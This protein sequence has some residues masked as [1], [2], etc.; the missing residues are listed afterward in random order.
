VYSKQYEFT[1]LKSTRKHRMTK[2]IIKVI[3]IYIIISQNIFAQQQTS[4]KNIGEKMK[5]TFQ[6]LKEITKVPYLAGQEYY[7]KHNKSVYYHKGNLELTELNMDQSYNDCAILYV[8]GDLIVKNNIDNSYSDIGTVLIVNGNVKAK[9]IFAGGSEIK[10][11]GIATIANSVIAYGNDGILSIDTL[12]TKLLIN[13]NH[14]VNI[15]NKDIDIDIDCYETPEQIKE[16]LITDV[17]EVEDD[18]CE[19]CDENDD[20]YEECMEDCVY[21]SFQADDAME[22]IR[23]EQSILK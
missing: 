14:D 6:E 17:Y 1:G 13:N 23:K 10:I 12:K 2:I 18:D 11:T 19:D 9:N 5:I 3:F 4:N 8:E 20:D 16:F 21:I 15:Q 7:E 22:L